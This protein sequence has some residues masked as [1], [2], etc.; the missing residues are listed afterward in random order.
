MH[1]DRT[2]RSL[3]NDWQR[4]GGAARRGGQEAAPANDAGGGAGAG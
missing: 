2:G 4:S 3:G 1:M